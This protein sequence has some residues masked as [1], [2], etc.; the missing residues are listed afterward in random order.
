MVMAGLAFGIGVGPSCMSLCLPV[1][2]PHIAIEHPGVKK[3]LLASILFSLG[4]LPSYLILGVV[5]GLF[6]GMIVSEY[7]LT[8][9][10]TL[11]LGCL[12]VFYGVFTA[13]GYHRKI[14]SRA[15]RY[16]RT[17][18]STVFLGFLASFKPCLPLLSA[19]AYST[20]L[21]NVPESL[22][23]MMSF[24]LGSSLLT[25]ILGAATG[26]LGSIASVHIT[27]E[28]VRRICGIALA[29]I[30]FTLLAE[31]IAVITV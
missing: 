14:D 8:A 20:T 29:I 26:G 6:G 16:L 23:F 2:A 24:W 22:L 12:L 30:G 17:G 31:G 15:C 18:R 10:V 28:R 5:F 9:P 21:G 11:V 4:R 7:L 3:G 19:V 13:M 25:V 1:L 27:T